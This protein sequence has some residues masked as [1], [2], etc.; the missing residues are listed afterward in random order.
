MI[1]TRETMFEP[2]NTPS[3]LHLRVHSHTG[4]AELE[5]IPWEVSALPGSDGDFTLII[6]LAEPSCTA[7]V[8]RQMS[9]CISISSRCTSIPHE[10]GRR[11]TTIE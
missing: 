10:G 7:G 5:G 1:V 8:L 9:G 3:I 6:P 11:H 2:G 4:G